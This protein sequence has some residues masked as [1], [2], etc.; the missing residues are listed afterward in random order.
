MRPSSQIF[1]KMFFESAMLSID[2]RAITRSSCAF[3]VSVSDWNLESETCEIV[4]FFSQILFTI[5]IFYLLGW[6]KIQGGVFY[7]NP[8]E[9]CSS[10]NHE[11]IF[12]G[13]PKLKGV[14]YFK[15]VSKSKGVHI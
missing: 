1:F 3:S 15:G 4:S 9:K 13:V 5:Q 2:K 11:K 8:A 12:L 10:Q 14:N 7:E 6:T